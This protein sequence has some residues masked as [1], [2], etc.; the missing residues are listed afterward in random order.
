MIK[1]VKKKNI[2]SISKYRRH[3]KASIEAN[4][5]QQF[6]REET[7]LTPILPSTERTS[8]TLP[9]K[10]FSFFTQSSRTKGQREIPIQHQDLYKLTLPK[11][12]KSEGQLIVTH[13]NVDGLQSKIDRLAHLLH[14]TNPD[15]VILTENELNSDNLENTRLIGY[16]LIAFCKTK[17]QKRRCWN[18]CK[19]KLAKCNIS[20]VHIKP[21]YRMCL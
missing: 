17:L 21:N 12:V 11:Q 14:N 3:C 13:Q 19:S 5:T 10:P 2:F 20:C 16:Q 7:R 4:T 15:I 6:G 18:L 1:V 9:K 8:Q